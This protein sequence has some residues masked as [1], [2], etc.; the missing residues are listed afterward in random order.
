MMNS[1]TYIK[2]VKIGGACNTSGQDL[3][4]VML[5]N[6]LVEK[7][8]WKTDIYGIYFIMWSGCCPF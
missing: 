5:L 2:R 1:L 8:F 7:E 6:N 3:A 4:Y